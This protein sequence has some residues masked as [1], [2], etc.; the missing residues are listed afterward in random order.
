MQTLTTGICL[1]TGCQKCIFHKLQLYEIQ[2][3]A[4]ETKTF[5]LSKSVCD[6]LAREAEKR[7]ATA[8]DVV[9]LAIA[10]FFQRKQLE[11]NLLA[12]E[13]RIIARID[14]NSLALAD[15]IKEILDLASSEEE[16]GK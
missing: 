10:D 4:T 13:Q 11:G 7:N 2:I 5:R 14:A 12:L 6:Q 9:R 8:A 3:M 1:C 15:G 16:D